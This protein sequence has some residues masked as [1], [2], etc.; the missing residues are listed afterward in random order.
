MDAKDHVLVGYYFFDKKPLI[1]KQWH[2]DMDFEKDDLKTVPI[3]VQLKLNLKHWGQK[4]LHKIAAQIGDPIKRDEATRNRDKLQ[5]A[6]I[7]IE[8]KIE[9][10]LPKSVHFCNEKGE[11]TEVPITFEWL[12]KHCVNCK[13]FGHNVSECRL[14]KVKQVWQPKERGLV[15]N[16]EQLVTETTPPTEKVDQVEMDPDGFQRAL[17]PIK[18]RSSVSAATSIHN[19]FQ[20]LIEEESGMVNV[21]NAETC[22]TS[23]SSLIDKGRIIIAW[24]ATSFHL[25][26]C[27]CSEQ[28]IHYFSKLVNADKGFYVI[29][30]YAYN[31][32]N[33]RLQ[34]WEALKKLNI[35]EPWLLCG[36]FNSIM[37]TEE[38]IG[39]PVREVEMVDLADCMLTCG[40]Q[41]I[42]ASGNFYTW[43][44]KQ[45]VADI[46]AYKLMMSA[47]QQLHV[48][49]RNMGYIEE[50]LLAT[51]DYKVMKHK[52]YVEFL[53]QKAKTS[54]IKEGDENTS[55][56]HQSIKARKMQNMVYSIY[57]EKGVWCDNLESA[58]QTFLTYYQ[59]LLGGNVS[60][61]KEVLQQLVQEAPVVTS[62]HRT[63]LTAPY[64]REE[65][66]KALFD[67]PGS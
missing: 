67:I 15:T 64:T 57:D 58:S 36:D 24:K 52:A 19:P 9:H 27:Q 48:D 21:K 11:L 63:I 56:F 29:F 45:E 28:Y 8:V 60:S 34:L 35:T 6:R 51:Q 33:R 14:K 44:N 47:Q 3:W 40:L 23:N 53:A 17:K 66:K 49:P 16:V 46:Q 2:S 13:G 41:D 62:E 32:R 7:L 20:A 4:S 43:T 59:A 12:P 39:A 54:W 26:I 22:F 18:V 61:R 5:F 55:L 25:N 10:H 31:E 37:S 42:K 50:E 1:I 30:I 38:R 65:V